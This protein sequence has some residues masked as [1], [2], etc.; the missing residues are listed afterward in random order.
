[1]EY[2]SLVTD[3]EGIIR[4]Q[5]FPGLWLA[6]SALLAEDMVKVMATLQAGLASKEHQEFCKLMRYAHATRTAVSRQ[7]SA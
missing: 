6:V 1:G 4:S 7:P 3:E 5:V 2:V